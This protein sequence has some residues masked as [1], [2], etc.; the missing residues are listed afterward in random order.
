MQKKIAQK[1][2][3]DNLGKN[4]RNNQIIFGKKQEANKHL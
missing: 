2:I 4:P 3:L 1:R